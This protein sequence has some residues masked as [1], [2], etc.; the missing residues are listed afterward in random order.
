MLLDNAQGLVTRTFRA[1]TDGDT[2]QAIILAN[3]R[4]IEL[5]WT[6]VQDPGGSYDDVEL[7]PK[8]LR[9]RKD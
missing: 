2:D 8:A 4:S 7:L 1:R 3:K 5:G 6:Q 9:R